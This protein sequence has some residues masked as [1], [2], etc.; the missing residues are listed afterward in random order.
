VIIGWGGQ[1]GNRVEM[2]ARPG[3]IRMRRVGMGRAGRIPGR[4]DRG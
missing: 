1:R 2:L 3:G 4:P